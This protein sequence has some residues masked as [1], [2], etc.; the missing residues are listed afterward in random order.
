[1]KTFN[2]ILDW[3]TVAK[4]K[5]KSMKISHT[6][7]KPTYWKYIQIPNTIFKIIID[8]FELKMV[9]AILRGVSGFRSHAELR[10]IVKIKFSCVRCVC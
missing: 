4:I 10:F 1:M 5:R 9:R 8:F 7:L 6:L 2:E 3:S